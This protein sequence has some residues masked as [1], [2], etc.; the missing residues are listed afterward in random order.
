MNDPKLGFELRKFRLA[1]DQILPVRQIKDPQKNVA[2]YKTILESIK[3]MGMIEPLVVHRQKDNSDS[4]LLLDGHLRLFALKA[5]G[6]TAADCILANDD[7]SFTYNARVNRLAAIQ[8]HKMIVRAVQICF[9][10][11][12]CQPAFRRRAFGAIRF[13]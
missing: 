1:L 13:S 4:Y 2:R 11:P 3:E 8:E 6:E 12:K 5:L 7:E 9:G 10:G